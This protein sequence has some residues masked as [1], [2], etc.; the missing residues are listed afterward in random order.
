MAKPRNELIRTGD[1]AL[2]A[3][4]SR[5][6]TAIAECH[7]I[8][9]C[10]NIATQAGAIAAYYK[11]IKDDESVRRFLQIKIRAWRRIGE[12]L[13]GAGVDKATCKMPPSQG[14]GF[15][16]AE[17]IRK[18]RAVFKGDSDV[19]DLS[20]NAFRHALKV[21]EMPKEFFDKHAGEHASIDSLVASFI[22]F[23]RREWEKSPEGQAEL[24]RQRTV[25]ERWHKNYQEQL[26]VQ[27]RE[28]RE[29]AQRDQEEAADI[30]A[31][32]A[33]RDAAFNEVGITLDRRDRKQ[34]H[35][36]VFLLKKQ[37]YETLRQAAFDHRTTMQA[38][39]RAGLM[40]WFI[41]HGYQ[42][43]AGDMKLPMKR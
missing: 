29:Q 32:L 38:V 4:Y 27:E 17:Y 16:M 3:L 39:L 21:A 14:D 2:P 15:N 42:V 9:D 18:I 41:A 43:P 7:S 23:Q 22:G 31:L 19:A 11:Q 12:I 26:K 36:I 34:M 13:N 37:V 5:M 25:D 35:Q 8:D 6:Q 28:R 33:E 20:D 30:N 10:K 24:K 1:A 40:M